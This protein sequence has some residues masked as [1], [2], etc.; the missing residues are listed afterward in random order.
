MTRAIYLLSCLPKIALLG[1]LPVV[2]FETR[3]SDDDEL[4]VDDYDA[5][6]TGYARIGTGTATGTESHPAMMR[7]V[8]TIAIDRVDV[9]W[10][11]LGSNQGPNDYESSALTD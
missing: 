9:G 7:L 5:T 1:W 3:K 6:V 10:A 8:S 2:R 4:L 11:R